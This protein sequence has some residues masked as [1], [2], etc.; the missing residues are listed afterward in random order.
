M[1]DEILLQ[2]LERDEIM[3]GQILASVETSAKLGLDNTA[4][5]SQNKKGGNLSRPFFRIFYN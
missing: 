1:R 4:T 2:N 3:G 5:S